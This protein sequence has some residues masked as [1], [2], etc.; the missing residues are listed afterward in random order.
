[1]TAWLTFQKHANT[2]RFEIN[3]YV[4]R[5]CTF[6]AREFTDENNIINQFLLSVLK[7]LIY[8]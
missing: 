4:I 5:Q 3:I 8:I 7:L 6:M 2:Q 1:M